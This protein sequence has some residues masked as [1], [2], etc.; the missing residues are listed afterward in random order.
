MGPSRIRCVTHDRRARFLEP[1]SRNPFWTLRQRRIANVV[2]DWY[3]ATSQTFLI[4]VIRERFYLG[5]SAN[6]KSADVKLF[7]VDLRFD[8]LANW[9]PP[10][11][12]PG[13]FAVAAHVWKTASL[14]EKRPTSVV[15]WYPVDHP[16]EAGRG[17]HHL[18]I[19]REFPSANG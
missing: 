12:L 11:A 6:V 14:I 9:R 5:A 1:V 2:G 16:A 7:S 4:Q 10:F 8:P 3:V 18:P 15:V 13:P 19:V 17:R